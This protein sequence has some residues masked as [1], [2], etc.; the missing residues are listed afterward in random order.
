MSTNTKKDNIDS[1]IDNMFK[2]LGI[3]NNQTGNLQSSNQN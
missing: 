2:D 1:I 3:D